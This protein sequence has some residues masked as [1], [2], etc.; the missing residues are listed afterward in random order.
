MS[1]ETRIEEMRSQLSSLV[2]AR[3]S[4]SVH[5]RLDCEPGV[6]DP[7]G[8][9]MFSARIFAPAQRQAT[10]KPVLGCS[11]LPS[12]GER[13]LV[14]STGQI[15]EGATDYTASLHGSDFGIGRYSITLHS[16]AGSDPIAACTVRILGVV[17]LDAVRVG[18]RALALAQQELSGRKTSLLQSLRRWVRSWFLRSS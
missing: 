14:K 18:I 10:F 4:E 12:F 9:I 3:A 1:D 7:G 17:P 8:R 16:S 11:Q 5:A 13:A 2:A 6:S 15:P